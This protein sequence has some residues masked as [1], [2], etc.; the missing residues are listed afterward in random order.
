MQ[1]PGIIIEFKKLDNGETMQETCDRA[2]EQIKAKKYAAEVYNQGIHRV[3]AFGVA[4]H[5][6]D[7][8]VKQEE[9]QKE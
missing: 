3:V 4:C 1:A 7:V 6:K 5:K 8:L 2:L 9:L